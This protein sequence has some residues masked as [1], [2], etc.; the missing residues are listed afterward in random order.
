MNGTILAYGEIMLRLATDSGGVSDGTRLTACYGGT[1]SNVLACLN[2]LGHNVEYL[3]ALPDNELGRE[4]VAHLHRYG[5]GTS[6]V[7]TAGD[8][9]GIYFV[10]PL[11]GSR[12][13][14]V[15]YQRKYSEFT[16]F[17]EDDVDFD[18][19]FDG[20]ELFHVSGISYALSESSRKL[21]FRLLEEAQNRGIYISFDFNYRSRLW[22]VDEARPI[23]A[24][25]ASYADV[26]LASTLD[27]QTF[28]RADEANALK[29]FP[30]C[31]CLSLRDRKAISEAEHVVKIKLITRRSDT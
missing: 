29:L 27:L 12:G 21:G 24:K 6:H 4:V 2:Q 8:A 22:T 17:C 16:R 14:G 10:Q 20:V 15:V 7:K 19:V 23:L 28:M 1:E 18:K 3:T 31:K 11:N 26:L 9:M 30:R 5:V 13:S 25:A